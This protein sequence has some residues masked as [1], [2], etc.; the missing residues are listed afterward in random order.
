MRKVVILCV[1]MLF[2]VSLAAFSQSGEEAPKPPEPQSP[3]KTVYVSAM[4]AWLDDYAAAKGEWKGDF[5]KYLDKAS[6]DAGHG[7]WK[8]VVDKSKAALPAEA[9]SKLKEQVLMTLNSPEK[10]I[11]ASTSPVSIQKM[12]EI[13]RKALAEYEKAYL[14]AED[15][16]SVKGYD[17]FLDEACQRHGYKDWAGFCTALALAV[18]PEAF[19]SAIKKMSDEMTKK[20]TEIYMKGSEGK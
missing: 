10:A 12:Q 8:A 1:A 6:K 9:W 11:V 2:A 18:P 17:K 4:K 5:E 15:K 13:Y 7:E 16:G 20:L 3:F 14:G 19:Q